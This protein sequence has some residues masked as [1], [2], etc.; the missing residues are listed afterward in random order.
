MSDQT[1]QRQSAEPKRN[2]LLAKL[3]S[4]DYDALI[5][6]GKVVTLK[7]RKNVFRQDQSIDAVYFP[8]TCMASLIVTTDSKP[9]M[10]MA[11][12]GREG[13]VGAELCQ[14]ERCLGFMLIQLAGTALRIPA[15]VFLK[16]VANR[17]ELRNIMDRYLYSQTRQILYAAACNRVHS[18]EERCARWVLMTHDRAGQDTFPL[19]QEFL[20]HML[21]VRRATVNVATGMLKKAGFIS[22]V[23]GRMTVLDRI[24]LES[25]ACDCYQAIKTAYQTALDGTR[26]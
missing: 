8:L 11:T 7:L 9:Q 6:G 26:A 20:S 4:Q 13:A 19:T 5:A 12:T 24:G 10:E 25:A 1:G 15:K 3:N 23:R 16:E 2:L 17:P 21:G 18:M 14:S 22:Y